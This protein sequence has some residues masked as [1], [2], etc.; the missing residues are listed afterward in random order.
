MDTTIT[1][2]KQ[3]LSSS[4]DIFNLLGN[5]YYI[6]SEKFTHINNLI[7][8]RQKGE[9]LKHY[10][11]FK[12][13]LWK[14][15]GDIFHADFKKLKELLKGVLQ[16]DGDI[17]LIKVWSF[18]KAIDWAVGDDA[19]HLRSIDDLYCKNSFASG[20]KRYR[21]LFKPRNLIFD[22]IKDDSPDGVLKINIDIGQRI[23]DR[24][25][26]LIF[27]EEHS[28]RKIKIQQIDPVVDGLLAAQGKDLAFAVAPIC[29]DFHYLFDPF[30]KQDEPHE[31]Y[32]IFNQIENQEMIAKIISRILETCRKEDVGIVV[33]PEL[34]I[35]GYLRRHIS[36]WLEKHNTD[37]KIIMVIAGS[38]HFPI[39]GKKDEFENTSVVYRYDGK[40]LMVDVGKS[41]EEWE[42]KKMHRFQLNEKDIKFLLNP[43]TKGFAEFKKIFRPGDKKAG[44][45]ITIADTLKIVDSSIGRMGICIC[46]DYFVK[47][48]QKL[49]VDPHVNLIFVPAMS[50][51]LTRMEK[52]DFDMGTWGMASVFCAN[53]CWIISGGDIDN[54]GEILKKMKKNKKE[55]R[56]LSYIYV[57]KI[58]G[59]WEL[60][61]QKKSCEQCKPLIYRISKKIKKRLD[62]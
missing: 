56:L 45:N 35:N 57:P 36:Q 3:T 47:E 15:G 34:T 1:E 43:A 53:S 52:T 12:E 61:C 24:L 60:D 48:N 41:Q 10:M 23:D 33:F 58:G 31:V 8:S 59:T 20:P 26:K 32:Y 50:I 22:S 51:S 18:L 6:C 46:L 17:F 40:P 21:L 16:D 14:N 42:Q 11:I 44:E 9:Y 49:L 39:D 27:Y 4:E 7:F 13:S 55:K 38:Y 28:S 5:L 19:I 30:R 2:M 25:G 62:K 54:L 37:R 29:C